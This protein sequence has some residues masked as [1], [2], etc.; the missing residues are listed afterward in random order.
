MA[1]CYKGYVCCPA[2][3]LRAVPCCGY[4]CRVAS[5]GFL[6][7]MQ[8]FLRIYEQQSCCSAADLAAVAAAMAGNSA[9]DA[10]ALNMA[11]TFAT[12]RACRSRSTG[13]SR[14][15]RQHL[16]RGT[17][18][19]SVATEGAVNSTASTPASPGMLAHLAHQLQQQQ[20]QQCT[21]SNA[22]VAESAG[23]G[24]VAAD[25]SWGSSGGR[26]T[27]RRKGAGSQPAALPL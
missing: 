19:G 13:R 22:Q 15:P 26:K 16:N 1:T 17:A 21:P 14:T 7:F 25:T 6:N 23:S 4:G 3:L 5:P 10:S 9:S 20:P 8:Q 24:A 18:G 12:P 2:L 11:S 27:G